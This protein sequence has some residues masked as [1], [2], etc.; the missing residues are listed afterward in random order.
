[1]VAMSEQWQAP[2]PAP[3]VSG[4]FPTGAEPGW[5]PD[6]TVP[7]LLRLWDGRHWGEETKSLGASEETTGPLVRVNASLRVF[8]VLA[9]SAIAVYL[10]GPQPWAYGC[11]SRRSSSRRSSCGP[12][13]TGSEKTS[14]LKVLLPM[15][16]LVTLAGL[17]AA[18]LFLVWLARAYTDR[19]TDPRGPRRG[20]GMAVLCWFIPV[21]SLW[22]PVQTMNDLWHAS[23]PDG[24]R[25][26]RATPPSVLGWWSL[27]LL[28][29]IGSAALQVRGAMT[30]QR[31][32]DVVQWAV[33]GAVFSLA[34][35][36]VSGVLLIV[37][38]TGVT[39]HLRGRVPAQGSPVA[40]PAARLAG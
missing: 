17:V 5:R 32:E 35:L 28:G 21:V 30:L 31:P 20:T 2:E 22:V 38:I 39:D 29:P 19:H 11:F 24:G 25:S 34:C 10:L 1:M 26:S 36:L 15:E 7:G 40:Q 18:V 27:Y 3:A 16:L 37:V 14:L 9:Q 8:A 23:K 4:H 33:A 13:L 6:P 12:R